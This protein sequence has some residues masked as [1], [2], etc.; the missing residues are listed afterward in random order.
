MKKEKK[1]VWREKEKEMET[2]VAPLNSGG[3]S[4]EDVCVMVL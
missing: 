1:Q 2:G 3:I 4:H